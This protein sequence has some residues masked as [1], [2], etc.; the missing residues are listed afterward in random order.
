M[1]DH[2]SH[3][4]AILVEAIAS[5]IGSAGDCDRDCLGIHGWTPRRSSCTPRFLARGL[6]GLRTLRRNYRLQ[7]LAFLRLGT[8][9]ETPDDYQS[10]CRGDSLRTPGCGPPAPGLA[11]AG[12]ALGRDLHWGHLERINVCRGY[13][14]GGRLPAPVSRVDGL[15]SCLSAR[16]GSLISEADGQVRVS[17]STFPWRRLGPRIGRL[18]SCCALAS[19]D[20]S[21]PSQP[22]AAPRPLGA[23]GPEVEHRRP[24]SKTPTSKS[25]RSNGPGTS[26]HVLSGRNPRSALEARGPIDSS[27]LSGLRLAA[28]LLGSGHVFKSIR[29]FGFRHQACVDEELDAFLV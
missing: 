17:P 23:E 6:A 9:G 16:I 5:G 13:G 10:G 11:M 28:L 19:A 4:I 14:L 15:G 26:A 27:L 25:R 24:V 7:L 20:H 22:G 2:A 18:R 8:G 12:T 21:S 1:K 29:S 3:R